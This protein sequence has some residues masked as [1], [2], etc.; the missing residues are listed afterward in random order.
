MLALRYCTRAPAG[1]RAALCASSARRRAAA[2][3]RFSASRSARRSSRPCTSALR[4]RTSFIISRMPRISAAIVASSLVAAASAPP[5]GT[6]RVIS[7]GCC[8]QPCSAS[9]C[10]CAFSFCSLSTSACKS[11]IF[12]LSSLVSP[13]LPPCL[14]GVSTFGVGSGGG[15]IFWQASAM[16]CSASTTD[17]W[18]GSSRASRACF[19]RAK[20]RSQMPPFISSRA[21]CSVLVSMMLARRWRPWA[22]SRLSRENPC[23]VTMSS[24]I[25]AIS[26]HE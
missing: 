3:S 2:R 5:R 20:I 6:I 4:R 14:P 17:G 19:A 12:L 15:G 11:T 16:S 22:R 9:R 13:S 1:K 10:S 7:A 18:L 25:S 26:E 23:L 24:R 21:C 8:S